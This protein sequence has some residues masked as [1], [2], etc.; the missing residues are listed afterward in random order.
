MQKFAI[1]L[2]ALLIVAAAGKNVDQGRNDLIRGSSDQIGKA[3][4]LQSG[5]EALRG[6]RSN[7]GS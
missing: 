2:L 6:R 1:G 3:S 5:V 7:K 4:L